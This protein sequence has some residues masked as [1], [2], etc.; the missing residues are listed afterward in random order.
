MN[1]NLRG[2]VWVMR[3]STKCK[4]ARGAGGSSTPGVISE[5]EVTG[6]RDGYWQEGRDSTRNSASG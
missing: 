6:C 2:D 4:S 3:A 5:A 1:V